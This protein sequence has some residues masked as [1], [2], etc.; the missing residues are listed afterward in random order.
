FSTYENLNYGADLHGG[1]TFNE[2]VLGLVSQDQ[3]DTR[4]LHEVYEMCLNID[5]V[6]EEALEIWTTAGDL[7]RETFDGG[8][9]IDDQASGN[10]GVVPTE[11][12]DYAT[13]YDTIDYT[14]SGAFLDWMAHPEPIGLD[15]T[16]LDFEMS[17]NHITGGNVYNPELFRMEVDGYRVCMRTIT[18]F[19]VNNSDTPTTEE[20]FS[21]RTETGGESVAY[22]TTGEVRSE[23]DALRVSSDDLVFDVE[24]V[25]EEV[26]SESY[27]GVLGPGTPATRTRESH[28]F[29]T[30]DEGDRIEATATWNADSTQDNELY[31][32]DS[33]G[34]RIAES[35]NFNPLGGG[36]S[37]QAPAEPDAEYTVV[38]ETYAN[39]AAA[40]EIDVSVQSQEVR[41]VSD[42]GS[43]GGGVTT[44]LSRTTEE[45]TVAGAA[46]TTLDVEEGLHSMGVD[47]QIDSLA[48]DAELVNPDGEVVAAY[49]GVDTERNRLGD[50]E[51]GVPPFTVSEPQAGTWT[52]RL[53][54][55]VQQVKRGQITFWTLAAPSPNPDPVDVF[56]Y[57]Q[58][59]YEATPLQFFEDYES[60][61][62]DGG[63]VEPVTVD[64]VAAGALSGYD[65][66]VV[67]HDYGANGDSQPGNGE[68]G[69]RGEDHPADGFTTAGY[70]DAIDEFVDSGGNL[71][72]TD[73]GLNLVPKL[74]NDLVEG[75][76]IDGTAVSSTS[77]YEVPRFTSKNLDH[78][79]LTDG[80]PIQNQ[81]WK[82]APL[83]YQAFNGAA[84]QAP[85]FSVDRLRPAGLH[86]DVLRE[87]HPDV[88][89]GLPAGPRHR[90]RGADVR[91]RGRVGPLRRRSGRP[92]GA[93]LLGGR[94]AV[95]R[96]QRLHGR[97]DQHRRDYRRRHRGRRLRWDAGDGHRRDPGWLDRR[98]GVRRRP[99]RRGRGRRPR[100]RHAGGRRRGRLGHTGVLRG[101]TRGRRLERQLQV[102]TRRRRGD[103]R[104]GGGVRRDSR[105]RH[106]HCRRRLDERI[107]DRQTSTPFSPHRPEPTA[108]PTT[109]SSS[110][111][112]GS[113]AD[114]PS[115]RS[116]RPATT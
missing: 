41:Q 30:A 33:E 13:I 54:G 62:E 51:G 8:V 25:H 94:L 46:E 61:I 36:E 34:T 44:E 12:F 76:R 2:F 57:E 50:K 72:L 67:I 99:L 95:R 80:R 23:E 74:E 21:T 29:T 24:I 10:I 18:A 55:R 3:F 116:S 73:A 92:A 26:Q 106:Q 88:G 105:H 83:G 69:Y 82:T 98:R 65:H 70:T 97:P 31:L 64:E 79:L 49:D 56:G 20:N 42:G 93:R 11:G 102:R 9:T 48:A 63:T 17:Y 6:L 114:T 110:A 66:A 75:S 101:G 52:F 32:E 115:R 59:D 100:H 5:A 35:K 84:G 47:V 86:G 28:S 4:E 91:P 58:R 7:N 81:L 87:P 39:A 53:D 77:S 16:T 14:V 78:P 60:F 19:A 108:C 43:G 89:A 96:R 40:Y 109:P 90:R 85:M 45:V 107:G 111:G 112:R 38:L 104:R 113:S 71:V 1:P 37:V 27:T 68:Y 22:V 103:H 15:L